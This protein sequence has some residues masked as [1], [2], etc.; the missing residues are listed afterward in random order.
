MFYVIE[1]RLS[2]AIDGEWSHAE[3]GSY[4]VI[5]GGTPHDFENHGAVPCGFISF[6]V[7]GGFELKVPG[8]VQWFAENP[9]EEAIADHESI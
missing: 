2:I 1:G 4:V 7:P 8:I 6:N 5:P 9:L 3:R